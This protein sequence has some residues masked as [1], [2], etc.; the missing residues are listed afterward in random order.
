MY[1]QETVKLEVTTVALTTLPAGLRRTIITTAPRRNM[2]PLL[3]RPVGRRNPP[4]RWHPQ[5]D[6]VQP[7]QIRSAQLR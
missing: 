5:R 3:E 6:G 2:G 4:K 1:N 7:D